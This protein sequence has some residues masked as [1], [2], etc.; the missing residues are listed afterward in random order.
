MKLFSRKLF[1]IYATIA[2]KCVKT[3][4]KEFFKITSFST[5]SLFNNNIQT[6]HLMMSLS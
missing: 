4:R 1:N 2:K 5:I 6:H 3:Y